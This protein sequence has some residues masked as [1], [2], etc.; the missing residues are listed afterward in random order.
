MAN[1]H[2]SDSGSGLPI[3]YVTAVWAGMSQADIAAGLRPEGYSLRRRA[4]RNRRDAPAADANV[5]SSRGRSPSHPRSIVH[6]C[7]RWFDSLDADL[8]A[9]TF[10]SI[11][12]HA[13]TTMPRAQRT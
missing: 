5:P 9:E 2:A 7:E 3:P 8:S 10:D 13:G 4:T 6:G 11:W 1:E 12:T